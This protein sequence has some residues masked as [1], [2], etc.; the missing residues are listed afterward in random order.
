M[1]KIF[2]NLFNFSKSGSGKQSA[3]TYCAN[4]LD[5]DMRV[6]VKGSYE[7]LLQ[8]LKEA[9]VLANNE[10]PQVILVNIGE[11]DPH[12]EKI[13]DTLNKIF[14]YYDIPG[15]FRYNYSKYFL[16]VQIVHLKSLL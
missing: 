13:F 1:D 14:H 6:N 3:L 12:A 10:N 11:N 15:V 4:M 8:N 2:H 5:F 7:A 9:Y 16:Y